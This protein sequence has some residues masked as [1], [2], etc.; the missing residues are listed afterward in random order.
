M[1]LGAATLVRRGNRRT[2][3]AAAVLLA[4]LGAL[5]HLALRPA[6]EAEPPSSSAL[7]GNAASPRASATVAVHTSLP[8]RQAPNAPLAAAATEPQSRATYKSPDMPYRFMGKTTTSGETAIVLFGRGR[9][10]TL[11]GPGRLDDEYMVEAVFDDYLVLRHVPTG[12]GRFLQF[13][14]RRAGIEPPRDPE[15]SPRD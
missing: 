9:V 1:T 10:V 7:P 14:H 8:T 13:A 2:A 11:R 5:A 6:A 15:D 3:L 4:M 12:F